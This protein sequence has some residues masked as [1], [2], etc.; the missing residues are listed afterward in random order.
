MTRAQRVQLLP[1]GCGGNV[2]KNLDEQKEE[3]QRTLRIVG[4]FNAHERKIPKLL[5]RRHERRS[6]RN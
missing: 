5:D 1:T 3:V 6:P 4:E 2:S